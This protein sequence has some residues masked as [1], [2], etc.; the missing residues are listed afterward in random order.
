MNDFS[1]FITPLIKT[2]LGLIDFSFFLSLSFALSI[3]QNNSCC[4]EK[5]IEY[6]FVCHKN[7]HCKK[8]WI[9]EKYKC[10]TMCRARKRDGK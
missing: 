7:K 6:F 4:Y 2:S 8:L 3:E 9:M 1:F 10:S 5:K